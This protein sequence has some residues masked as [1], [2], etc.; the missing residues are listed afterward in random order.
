MSPSRSPRVD[1]HAHPG[2]CFLAGIAPDDALLT[3]LGGDDAVA[4]HRPRRRLREW[5]RSVW[6]RSPTSE[7]CGWGPADSPP[8]DRSNTAKPLPTIVASSTRS[9]RSHARPTRRSSGVRTTSSVLTPTAAP[10]C[11]SRAR[12]PTSW[13]T[14][15]T[16]TCSIASP[17]PTRP[18]PAR[19]RSCTI[20]RTATATSRPSLRCTTGCLRPV[21]SWW[22]R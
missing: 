7:C 1:I 9:S 13:R 3:A 21:A 5:A 18:G 12:E 14:A 20:G 2:R 4:A 6:P 10:V 19:S 16:P 15:R 22:R 8:A 11:S 17:M